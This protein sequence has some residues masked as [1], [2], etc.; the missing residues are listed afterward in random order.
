M[1]PILKSTVGPFVEEDDKF[2]DREKE[3]EL[4]ID[5][6][7]QGSHLLLVAPRRIGK[8]S[9]M[10]RA[11]RLIA[12]RYICLQVDLQSSET[13]ADAVTQL[14]LATCA[15]RP[16]WRKTA[17]IFSN[18]LGKL[19]DNIEEVQI[20][21]VGIK[22][23]SGVTEG[24]WQDKGNQLFAVLAATEKP[25]VVFLDEVPILVNRLLKGDDYQI[26]P[27]RRRQ[28]DSFL[29]WLRQISIEHQDKVRLVV[30]GSIG[31][32]PILRQADLSATINTLKPFDL[33]A[34]SPEVAKGCVQALANGTELEFEPQALQALVDRL[35]HCIPHHVQLFFDYIYKTCRTK[36]IKTV[37]S[38]LV[39]QV[40]KRQMLSTRG[41]AELSHL[42]ERLRM[43]LGPELHPL[44]LDLLS[45]AALADHL[46]PQAARI[47]SEEFDIEGDDRP[48]TAI[49]RETLGILQHDGYL[50][51]GSTGYVFVSRL[52]QDWW[53]ARFEF[54]YTPVAQR[55]G[56]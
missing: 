37:T 56:D 40:Y 14:S 52:L 24:D 42:E 13:A 33:E 36:D 29:S 17:G 6:L 20:S 19:K 43:V 50:H 32:E 8:T 28:A 3:L 10:R 26:T 45:E 5:E 38:Q 27:Q 31:L 34:W 22:L 35:G 12:N 16:L 51:Q 11:A 21:E 23:R 2:W 15:H 53:K 9:L 39:D 25:V 54:F 49:L 55:Q 48:R 7:D 44:A 30:T 18:V 46:T 4:F 1:Q 47:L 41:H